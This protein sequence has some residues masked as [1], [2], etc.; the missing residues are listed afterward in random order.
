MFGN[1]LQS[2]QVKKMEASTHQSE[3][4]S[5]EIKELRHHAE[6][7]YYGF[8]ASWFLSP[9]GWGVLKHACRQLN[10][11]DDEGVQ[12]RLHAIKALW[13]KRKG[14]IVYPDADPDAWTPKPDNNDPDVK[15]KIE[16]FQT[17]MQVAAMIQRYAVLEQQMDALMS[18]KINN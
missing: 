14:E 17:A 8:R 18:R 6:V 1:V 16:E 12:N 13:N 4:V 5:K 9:D 11:S 15:A 10:A 2:G 3:E 7:Y